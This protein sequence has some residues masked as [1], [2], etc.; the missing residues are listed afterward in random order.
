M[1]KNN[2][3]SKN[4][5][6]KAIGEIKIDSP[7]TLQTFKTNTIAALELMRVELVDIENSINKADKLSYLNKIIITSVRLHLI[8]EEIKSIKHDYLEK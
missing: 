2:L 8:L 6:E 3:F 5:I 1:K 4:I 7:I